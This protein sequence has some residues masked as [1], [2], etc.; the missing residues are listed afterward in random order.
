MP[1]PGYEEEKLDKRGPWDPNYVPPEFVWDP[2]PTKPKPWY[3]NGPVKISQPDGIWKPPDVYLK[4]KI[5]R[6]PTRPEVG[7]GPDGET[8]VKYGEFHKPFYR[9]SHLKPLPEEERDPGYVE[10]KY[11]DPIAPLPP[12]AR[13]WTQ[14]VPQYSV[15]PQ[16]TK[17]EKPGPMTH[18]RLHKAVAS[19][20]KKVHLN[21]VERFP[22]T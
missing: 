17:G 16:K 3:P 9:S 19:G 15:V 11:I 14:R 18:N 10:E 13:D 6:F 7:V 22:V 1:K 12:D 20:D 5:V 4:K 8:T 21:S 2:D